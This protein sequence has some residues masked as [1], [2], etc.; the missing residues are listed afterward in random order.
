MNNYF[1]WQTPISDQDC[2]DVG[3]YQFDYSLQL[4]DSG[5]PKWL[6]DALTMKI[7]VDKETNCQTTENNGYKLPYP[8]MGL[9]AVAGIAVALCRERRKQRREDQ[10]DEED[11]DESYLADDEESYVEMSSRVN[12][13]MNPTPV[14]LPTVV[15]ELPQN[16]ERESPVQ[17]YNPPSVSQNPA[18]NSQAGNLPPALQEV[19]LETLRE[20]Y[21]Q[22]GIAIV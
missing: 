3:D 9:G 16:P 8:L 22:H 12:S 19:S 1:D 13:F 17:Q 21:E 4:P 2:G 5:V 18:S 11:D 15:E 7:Y 20:W 10:D 14:T 6:F